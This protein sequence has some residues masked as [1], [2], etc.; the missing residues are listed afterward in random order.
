MGEQ[1]SIA[2]SVSKDWMSNLCSI[3]GWREAESA[4][5]GGLQ[6]RATQRVGWHEKRG[7][8]SE[9]SFFE[10]LTQGLVDMPQKSAS[11]MASNDTESS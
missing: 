5:A 6:T 8:G 1:D 11:P 4:K 10:F 3:I 2:N 9:G 7:F